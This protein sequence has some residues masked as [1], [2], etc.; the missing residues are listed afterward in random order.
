[1]TAPA[2]KIHT[3]RK[4]G[5]AGGQNAE[6]GIVTQAVVK[7]RKPLPQA[8]RVQRTASASSTYSVV[9]SETDFWRDQA[10]ERAW[11]RSVESS[12]AMK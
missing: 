11:H 10:T 7:D 2:V 5:G 12:S 8:G 9:T 4:Q 3:F 6:L 1:L